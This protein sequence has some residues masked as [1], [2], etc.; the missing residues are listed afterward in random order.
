[1]GASV[2]QAHHDRPLSAAD[3]E[4]LRAGP[5]GAWRE[6]QD[7][8]CVQPRTMSAGC[9]PGGWASRTPSIRSPPAPRSHRPPWR[10]R[11]ETSRC[12]PAASPKPTQSG[13]WPMGGLPLR[14]RGG[15]S[16]EP[17][18]LT[19]VLAAVHDACDAMSRIASA[20]RRQVRALAAA[21]QFL[22]AAG[23]EPGTPWTC[24]D[25]WPWRVRTGSAPCSRCTS[26]PPKPAPK[27]L[28]LMVLRWGRPQA[29]DA[30]RRRARASGP[31]T[32]FPCP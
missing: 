1:M 11:P 30:R 20:D 9:A 5:A 2:R 14:G 10:L 17:S 6:S 7:S 18:E 21:G 3:L 16:R 31:G 32:R 26:T 15:H 29:G 22:V 8:P 25:P 23:P 28:P 12:G 24:W 13:R 4:L 19:E 27:R